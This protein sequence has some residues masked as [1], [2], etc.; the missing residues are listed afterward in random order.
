[1]RQALPVTGRAG[2]EGCETSSLPYFLDSRLTDDG[3]VVSVTRQAN[4]VTGR[5]GP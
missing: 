1:M 2:P 5:A 3:E 4:A